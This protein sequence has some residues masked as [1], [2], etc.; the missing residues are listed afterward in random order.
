MKVI[1]GFIDRITRECVTN[2]IIEYRP[3]YEI[4]GIVFI[5]FA[6]NTTTK[7]PIIPQGYNKTT[8]LIVY[9]LYLKEYISG[10]QDLAA[11][12]KSREMIIKTIIGMLLFSFVKIVVFRLIKYPA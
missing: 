12:S 8:F 4:N 11:N 5:S 6:R 10:D 7:V 9:K 3:Q 2:I 1:N